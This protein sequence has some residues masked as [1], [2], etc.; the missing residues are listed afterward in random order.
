MLS[1][2]LS[3]IPLHPQV[4]PHTLPHPNNYKSELVNTAI[5]PDL[6]ALV[7]S[8]AQ[9]FLWPP[10]QHAAIQHKQHVTIEVR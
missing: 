1:H 9:H 6:A 10:L 7:W 8:A 2:C 5:V 4:F 3:G